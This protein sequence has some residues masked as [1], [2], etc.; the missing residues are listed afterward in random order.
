MN[1]GCTQASKARQASV[2]GLQNSDMHHISF[3]LYHIL[4]Y[5]KKVI[6]LAAEAAGTTDKNKIG[7]FASMGNRRMD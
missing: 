5:N 6:F 1:T 4:R 3:V 7:D 2:K